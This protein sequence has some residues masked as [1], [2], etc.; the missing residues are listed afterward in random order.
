MPK[1]NSKL[2]I[3]H[4]TE[5]EVIDFS[6]GLEMHAKANCAVEPLWV[7]GAGHNDI[8]L[9]SVYLERLKRFVCEDTTMSL[10]NSA[11]AAANGT[12]TTVSVNGSNSV[13]TERHSFNGTSHALSASMK[14]AAGDTKK[15]NGTKPASTTSSDKKSSDGGGGGGS[16][17]ISSDGGKSKS[18]S[19]QLTHTSVLSSGNT[20]SNSS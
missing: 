14:T 7:E 9:Y 5:D 18:T 11:A 6:H 17:S 13:N 1:I 12:T 10:G 15:N 19:V 16:M 8:E 2:L 3:I 20:K 4:G